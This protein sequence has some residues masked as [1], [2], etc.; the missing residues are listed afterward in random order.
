MSKFSYFFWQRTNKTVTGT[1]YMWGLLIANHVDQSLWSTNQK[2]WAAFRSD[3]LHCFSEVHNCVAPFTSHR[4]LHEYGA[5]NQFPEQNRHILTFLQINLTVWSHILSTIG[6]ALMCPLNTL[7]QTF[8]CFYNIVIRF[9]RF[10]K[11]QI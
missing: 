8:R 1:A 11:V 5:E 6:D 9:Q 3:L 4:K 10:V 2:Y 7:K